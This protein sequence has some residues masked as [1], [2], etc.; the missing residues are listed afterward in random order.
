MAR[1]QILRLVWVSDKLGEDAIGVNAAE[2]GGHFEGD[3]AI[4]QV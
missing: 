1:C 3:K 4:Y 2:L